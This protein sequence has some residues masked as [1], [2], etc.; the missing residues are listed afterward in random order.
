MKKIFQILASLLLAVAGLSGCMCTAVK[1]G[2]D[3]GLIEDEQL[4]PETN[5]IHTQDLQRT[6]DFGN[7]GSVPLID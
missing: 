7:G 6:D 4:V 3:P 5:T 2:P 1:Y